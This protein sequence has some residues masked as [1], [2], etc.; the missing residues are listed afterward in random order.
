MSP[1][2]RRTLGMRTAG[3]LVVLRG[4]DI[5]Q[6][7]AATTEVKAR[8]GFKVYWGH[9]GRD[10]VIFAGF[11]QVTLCESSV[12]TSME[13]RRKNLSPGRRY[14]WRSCMPRTASG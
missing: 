1:S 6:R 4:H 7:G 5:A 12:G 11:D 10:L 9:G 2:E 14:G 3:I 8:N 13:G